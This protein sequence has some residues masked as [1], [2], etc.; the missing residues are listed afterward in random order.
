MAESGAAEA[1][2]VSVLCLGSDAFRSHMGR[3][4]RLVATGSVIRVTDRRSGEVLAWLTHTSPAELA[5]REYMLPD[6]QETDALGPDDEPA[7]EP[8]SGAWVVRLDAPA[9]DREAEV[10]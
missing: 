6:P 8:P 10:A 2:E 9:D 7:P 5:G 4:W 1:A 3:V